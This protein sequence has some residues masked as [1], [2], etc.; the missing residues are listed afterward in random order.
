MK[1]FSKNLFKENL[2]KNLE[3]P[4]RK[5]KI[6][7]LGFEINQHGIKPLVSKTEAMQRLN[8]PITCKRLISF[9]GNVHDLTKFVP[10]LAIQFRVFREMLKKEKKYTW[11]QKHQVAFENK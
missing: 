11:N 2:S 5:T 1:N 8:S 9:L 3:K 6:E 10:N 7:W 4:L